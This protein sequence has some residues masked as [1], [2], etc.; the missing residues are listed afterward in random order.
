M[1]KI[2]DKGIAKLAAA[3]ERSVKHTPMQT[4]SLRS[5]MNHYG[6]TLE[7]AELFYSLPPEVCR[8]I[9]GKVQEFQRKHGWPKMLSPLVRGYWRDLLRQYA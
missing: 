3:A 5:A 6:L 8:D 4:A 1:R 9:L 7:E 2:R